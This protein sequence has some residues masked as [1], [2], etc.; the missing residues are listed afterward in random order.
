MLSQPA[1]SAKMTDLV[2]TTFREYVLIPRCTRAGTDIRNVKLSTRL[3]HDMELAAPLMSSAMEAVTGDRLAIALAQH[4]GMGVLPAGNVTVDQQLEYL[5]AV[6]RFKAGFVENVITVG[7]DDPIARLIELEHQHGYSTFPVVESDGRLVGLITEKKY[8]PTSDAALPVKERMI[9]LEHLVVGR[10]GISLHEANRQ[11]FE[12]GIGVLPI[13]DDAQKLRSV[14]FFTDL[15]HVS[16]YPNASVDS[17]KRLRVAAAVSTHLEDRERARALVHEGA[18][19]LVVDASDGYSEYMQQTLHDL[20]QL[21]VPVVA[22]NVVDAEGFRF[23]AESGADAVK[24]G[25]GSGSICTTRRVKSIGRGQATAVYQNALARDEFFKR[26]GKYV[27]VIS[28]GGIESTGDM[29]AALALGAD[30]LMMGKYF[31]GFEESP[32]A[33]FSKRLPVLFSG[34]MAEVEV[35]V[36]AYWGEAS[37]RAK[38]VRR[39]QQDDPRSFVI[40]GE[41]GYVLYKGSL[42]QGV[43]RDL[44]ALRGTLSSCGCDNLQEFYRDVV[45]ERLT[46]EAYREGGTSIF[47]F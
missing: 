32:T 9:P 44:L 47:R 21:G 16:K 34:Q 36:K 42:H 40:E 4:G 5:R 31:A 27:P 28:D 20:K 10:H 6:K 41:E 19:V 43:T 8:N 26:T 35:T 13:V 22:G 23:L 38:N 25:I 37:A 45:A 39:Y 12:S 2:S 17:H 7:P 11:I 30:V 46:S 14:V 15:K 1:P 33:T 24:V 18:D 3:T 29:A